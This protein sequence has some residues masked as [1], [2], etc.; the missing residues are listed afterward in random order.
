MMRTLG[1]HTKKENVNLLGKKKKKDF[2]GIGRMRTNESTHTFQSRA[3][4]ALK[5]W[6]FTT[7]GH[8]MIERKSIRAVMLTPEG[9]IL[10]M[11]AQEPASDFKVWFAPGG[12]MEAGES[13]EECLRREIN[14]ETGIVLRDIGPLIWKRHHAYDWNGSKLSQ[15]ED[16]HLVPIDEFEPD[17]T[18]NPSETELMAFRQFRWWTPEEISASADV[19]APRQLA[20]HLS[21][22][23]EMG[24]P[25]ITINVGI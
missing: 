3:S 20:R 8:D 13:P 6:S 23:I 10:L 21:D 14:E 5:R 16:Y 2:S 11:Q 17:F 25:K 22:L 19:F 24:P 9:K 15:H 4:L 18:T 12:G 7:L 1:E